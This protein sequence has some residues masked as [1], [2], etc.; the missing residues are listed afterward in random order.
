MKPSDAPPPRRFLGPPASS[1]ATVLTPRTVHPGWRSRGYLPHYD[2]AA[3]IQHVVFGLAD[4]LPRNATTPS[5]IHADRLLDQGHGSCL[6][7]RAD[8]AE[9]VQNALL[10]ADGERYR[11]LA[12]CIMPNHVH[13]VVE[14]VEGHLLGSLVQAWKSTASHLINRLVARKGRLWRREYFDR[15]MRDDDHLMTTIA[16]V[17]DNPVKAKLAKTAPE[18]TW[19]SAHHR[20]KLAG[21][22]AGGPRTDSR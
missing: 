17:E 7:R 22:D 16:Y 8:C 5:A 11:L 12:W 1:P 6:L 3:L 20:T 19:S 14:L 18:W 15:F 10:H 2:D 21:E 9:F 4:S 13:V